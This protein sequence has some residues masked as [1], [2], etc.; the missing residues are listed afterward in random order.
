M[1]AFTLRL[2]L[3]SALCTL[4]GEARAAM[5]QESYGPVGVDFLSGNSVNAAV[6]GFASGLGT[7]SSVAI[8]FDAGAV[9]LEGNAISSKIGIYDSSGTLLETILFPSMTG[10]AQQIEMGNFA[11]PAADLGDFESVGNV[12]LKLD[13]TT[14]CRGSAPTPSGCNAF[15]GSVSGEVTYDFTPSAAPEPACLGLLAIGLTTLGLWHRVRK[16]G[17]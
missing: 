15:T 7:L 4:S 1:K 13:P 17:D 6:T 3:A 2:C 12:D 10:R 5:I 14:A 8:T 9:L 11:V 16:I